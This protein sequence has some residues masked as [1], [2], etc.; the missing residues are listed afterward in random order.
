MDLTDFQKVRDQIGNCGAWCGSCVVGNGTLRQLTAR[1]RQLLDAYGVRVW[2]AGDFNYAEF[3]K[4]L[5][6][7]EEV[8]S[9]SGCRQGGGRTDC[10]IRSCST[11]R[12]FRECSDCDDESNCRH[13]RV[14]DYMRTASKA[15]GVLFRPDGSV[16][17]EVIEE[18][19]KRLTQLWP[20]SNLFLDEG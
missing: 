20:S 2:G 10:E 7:I 12:G 9:C 15:A 13:Q 6:S 14:V 17:V 8:S 11:E 3:D 18:L 5:R 1:Y 4:G 16:G 19:Q